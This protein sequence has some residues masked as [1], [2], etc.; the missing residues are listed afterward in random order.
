MINKRE[1]IFQEED[2]VLLKAFAAFAA[3]SLQ[4]TTVPVPLVKSPTL[5]VDSRFFPTDEERTITKTWN[6]QVWTYNIEGLVRCIIAIFESFGLIKEFSIPLDRLVSCI[7]ALSRSYRDVPYHNFFHAVDVFQTVF[8]FLWHGKV[9]QGVFS[10][11]EILAL[12]VASLCHDIDHG[13]LNNAFHVKAQTPLALL[14]KDMSVLET[15][16]CSK[17]ISLLSETDNDILSGLSESQ[18][19]DLWKLLIQA[20]L[21]TDMSLHFNLLNKFEGLVKSGT[22][23]S[24]PT[25]GFIYTE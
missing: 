6:F 2:K 17:S 13:G 9:L 25:P 18:S 16:H 19:S 12:L 7:L 23:L 22:V 10:K 15:H 1:G 24:D 11:L 14:Y 4:T 3:K 20:I 5:G 8:M 21:A